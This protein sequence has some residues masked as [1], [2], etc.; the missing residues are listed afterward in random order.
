[1]SRSF[2]TEWNKHVADKD[3]HKRL[4]TTILMAVDKMKMKKTFFGGSKR[5]TNQTIFRKVNVSIQNENPLQ[6]V[7]YIVGFAD[8]TPSRVQ[9]LLR[10]E[11]RTGR[12]RL[13]KQVQQVKS[14]MSR[15]RPLSRTL[16]SSKS[17]DAQQAVRVASLMHTLS[18]LPSTPSTPL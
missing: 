4:R 14:K 3:L 11:L 7:D 16:S 9:T 5:P 15:S 1:M 10:Q 8:E 17:S 6:L 13:Q 12:Q 2:Q 18:K